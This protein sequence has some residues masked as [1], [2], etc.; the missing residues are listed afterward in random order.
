MSDP[1]I[2]APP[3]MPNKVRDLSMSDPV[4][5]ETFGVKSGTIME[6]DEVGSRSGF[7]PVFIAIVVMSVVAVVYLLGKSFFG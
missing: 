6:E 4:V 5:Q 1:V 3:S 7:S 2:A